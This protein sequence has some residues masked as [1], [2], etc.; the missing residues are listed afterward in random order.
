MIIT[1][2]T[3][4]ISEPK[5]EIKVYLISAEARYDFSF[6]DL[7]EKSDFEPII[8]E[9]KKQGRIYSLEGF[10]NAFNFEEVSTTTDYIL[11]H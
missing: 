11:I 8:E 5:K 1:I 2:D 7:I 6:N 3:E 10:Q 4:N 9:A